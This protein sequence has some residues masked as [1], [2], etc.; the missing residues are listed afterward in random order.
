[1][2]PARVMLPLMLPAYPWSQRCVRAASLPPRPITPDNKPRLHLPPIRGTPSGG[3]HPPS[4]SGARLEPFPYHTYGKKP[5]DE[6][7]GQTPPRTPKAGDKDKAYT[8]KKHED[9]LQY[10][11][12]KAVTA[13]KDE[14]TPGE[15]GQQE[16]V[17]LTSFV[18]HNRYSELERA[19]GIC[20]RT[21]T[22]L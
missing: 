6:Y 1:M 14:P 8:R 12:V 21:V 4:S 16:W 18:R 20:N 22:A 5:R 19:L 3:S 7:L 9:L 2:L 15:Q 13:S 11:Q 10:L 17:R